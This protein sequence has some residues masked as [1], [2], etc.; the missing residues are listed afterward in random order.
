M[1]EPF[2]KPGELFS[3]SVCLN[4]TKKF[5]LHTI[6]IKEYKN[7]KVNLWEL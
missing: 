6:L 5:G 1:G 7:G 3:L 2:N 4:V